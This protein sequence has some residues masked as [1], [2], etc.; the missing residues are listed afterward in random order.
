[1]NW[2]IP[3]FAALGGAVLVLLWRA[4]RTDIRCPNCDGSKR[5]EIGRNFRETREAGQVGVA[6][7]TDFQIIVDVQYRC[8]HCGHDWTRPEIDR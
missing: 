1:M 3:L 8:R 4:T 2:L 7:Q 5:D 6:S